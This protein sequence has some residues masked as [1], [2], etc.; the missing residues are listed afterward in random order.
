MKKS[1][2][3]WS[4]ASKGDKFH[5][6]DGARTPADSEAHFRIGRGGRL[7]LKPAS[8]IRFLR[9][10]TG[11]KGTIGLQV[12]VGEADV[13]TDEGVLSLDSEFGPILI[14]A[15]SAVT[16]RRQ[17]QNMLVNVDLGTIEI[18]SERRSVQ[19]GQSIELEMGG[20]E[21]VEQKSQVPP[22][23]EPKESPEEKPIALEMGDGVSK[24]DLV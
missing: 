15:N 24:Y 17:G 12:E 13:R 11:K 23:I 5:E 16:L 19:A 1:V 4:K 6:G 22:E 7:R 14:E 20:I 9:N 3:D 8:Q 2:A 10:H 18:G 21:V